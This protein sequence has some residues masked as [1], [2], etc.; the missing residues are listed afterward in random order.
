MTLV[1]SAKIVDRL[2][3]PLNVPGQ[4]AAKRPEAWEHTSHGSDRF[5]RRGR[6]TWG[7][8]YDV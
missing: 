5:G 6:R 4:V 3:K 2:L 8:I 1:D 7:G